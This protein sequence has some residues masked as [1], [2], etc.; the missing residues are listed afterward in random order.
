MLSID[1]AKAVFQ[2]LQ[3]RYEAMRGNGMKGILPTVTE[4]K[5]L[6]KDVTEFNF[7]MEDIKELTE[8][9]PE[10]YTAE[11]ADAILSLYDA[12]DKLYDDTYKLSYE[13]D[14]Q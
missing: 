1:K 6:E 14:N 7:V 2:S 12:S 4:Y 9:H 13:L 10:L 3:E 8:E 11:D 5:K